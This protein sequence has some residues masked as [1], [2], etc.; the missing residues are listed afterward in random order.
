[1][2]RRLLFNKVI[3]VKET[4][5]LES[6]PLKKA[7][8]MLIIPTICSE[9]I[10]LVYNLADTWFIAQTGDENQVAAVTL[11]FPVLMF[12]TVISS[13]FGIGGGSLISRLLGKRDQENAT[14][15]F[16]FTV[17][18]GGFVAILF[19]VLIYSQLPSLLNLLSANT[20]THGFAKDYII[21]TTVIGGLPFV[22]SIILSN[23]IRA[24]GAAKIAGIGLSIGCILNIIMDSI[25]VFAFR[26]GVSGT[27]LSTALSNFATLIFFIIYLCHTSKNSAFQTKLFSALPSQDLIYQIFAIG[28]P[29]ALQKLLAAISNGILMRLMGS[30]SAA[31]IAG[32][33][34]AI[35]ID[36]I[37]FHIVQGISNG[38]LPLVAFNYTA[39]NHRRMN[40]AVKASFKMG[41]IISAIGFLATLLFATFAMRL[42]INNYETV[43][44]GAVFLRIRSFSIPFLALEFMLIAFFQAI[45]GVKQAFILSVMR[46]GIVDVALMYLL[47]FLYPL[48]G[49]ML[50]QPI[51]EFLGFTIAILLYQK[52]HKKLCLNDHQLVLCQKKVQVK[53]STESWTC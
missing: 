16:S 43:E 7:I 3:G 49:L 28:T 10:M 30:Y 21:Y 51:M 1:M 35:K 40:D 38:I 50:V 5:V 18:Y 8:R 33:G 27:A 9:L 11:A 32:F 14:K 52:T 20:Q 13:M 26:M 46:K 48:Y 41:L 47:N 24:K 15:V 29:A 23:I 36:H 34:I 53:G 17:L 44:L 22:L 25:F 2:W 39:K 42:F 12:L 19:S 4:E 45:G 37:P 6:L 31:A